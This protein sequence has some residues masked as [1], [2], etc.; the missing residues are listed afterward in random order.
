MYRGQ[1][2]G[3]G[4]AHMRCGRHRGRQEG[5][6]SKFESKQR[7][8]STGGACKAVC[9]V[10]LQLQCG[11]VCLC[12]NQQTRSTH[13]ALH[14]VGRRLPCLASAAANIVEFS[15]CASCHRNSSR[16]SCPRSC[17]MVVCSTVHISKGPSPRRGTCH[18][19]HTHTG[20]QSLHSTLVS[21]SD[22]HTH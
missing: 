16:S 15:C 13:A 22:T 6:E 2:C 10:L 14:V 17:N 8:G 21:L 19:P 18:Q 7:D 20:P 9:T 1:A 5:F 3:M 4:G 11:Q 12:C